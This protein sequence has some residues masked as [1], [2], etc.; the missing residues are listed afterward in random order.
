MLRC[1]SVENRVDRRER[2]ELVKFSRRYALST[3]FAR[4]EMI[5]AD[6]APACE[7]SALRN[8]LVSS[9]AMRP[10]V[11]LLDGVLTTES[12]TVVG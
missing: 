4:T 10:K 9:D 3:L 1:V 5:C 8:C 12:L 2:G 7:M 11:V 6:L